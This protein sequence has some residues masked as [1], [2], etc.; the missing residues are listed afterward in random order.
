MS[1]MLVSGIQSRMRCVSALVVAT[2]VILTGC[3]SGQPS[4]DG[5][6]RTARVTGKAASDPQERLR[7]ELGEFMAYF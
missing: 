2:L 1:S 5:F 7:D 3:Q 4:G 6:A